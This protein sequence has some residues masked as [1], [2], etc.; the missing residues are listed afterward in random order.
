MRATHGRRGQSLLEFT[1]VGI[2][3]IFVLISIFEIARGMWIYHTLAYAVKEATRLAIV[4]GSS[5]VYATG[6]QFVT[7]GRIVQEVRQAGVG[8]PL[9]DADSEIWLT[10]AD[11][12]VI[13]CKPAASCLTNGD[14]WP[15]EGVSSRNLPVSIEVVVPFRSALAMFW[16]ISGERARV[17]GV[18]WL[19]A[20]SQD[21]IQF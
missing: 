2:P 16:P 14:R 11:T 10:S 12:G 15:P 7:V 4:K 17:F 6:G 5:Y 21:L 1:L 18:T 13:H 8:L 19:R 20:R 3:M 9:D